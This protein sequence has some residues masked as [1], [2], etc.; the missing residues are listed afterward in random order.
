M[1]RKE[2]MMPDIDIYD[3]EMKDTLQPNTRVLQDT[4]NT[5][6]GTNKMRCNTHQ[7]LMEEVMGT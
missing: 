6:S 4:M 3:R 5:T 1:P 2:R 7:Q